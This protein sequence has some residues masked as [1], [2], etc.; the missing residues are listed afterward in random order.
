[1]WSFTWQ[2]SDLGYYGLSNY[3]SPNMSITLHIPISPTPDSL[4]ENRKK[5][6]ALNEVDGTDFRIAMILSKTFWSY[7]F[8]KSGVSY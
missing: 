2:L 8:Q 5:D 4:F 1:M 7:T 3:F 6:D